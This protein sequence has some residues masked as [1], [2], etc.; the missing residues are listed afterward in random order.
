[1]QI[2]QMPVGV[3]LLPQWRESLVVMRSEVVSESS[4]LSTCCRGTGATLPSGNEGKGKVL[5]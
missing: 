2:R 1:M 5:S 4:L 3:A